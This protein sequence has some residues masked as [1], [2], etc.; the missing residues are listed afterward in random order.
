MLFSFPFLSHFGAALTF[1]LQPPASAAMPN[2]Q[3]KK[4]V[5]LW[6]IKMFDKSML[7]AD[8]CLCV[9]ARRGWE[10]GWLHF[11]GVPTCWIRDTPITP[12]S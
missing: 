4:E 2:V 12:V 6:E 8:D 3:V 10:E 11:H 7:H 5:V 1:Q 9:S